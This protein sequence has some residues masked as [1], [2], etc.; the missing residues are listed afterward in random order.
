MRKPLSASDALRQVS[1]RKLLGN[2]LNNNRFNFLREPS[3]APSSPGKFRDRSVSV[4]RKSNEGNSYA[5]VAAAGT[6]SSSQ[7]AFYEDISETIAKV[8]SLCE[9]TETALRSLGAEPEII[10]VLQDLS[11]AV[12]FT[13]QIQRDMLIAKVSLAPPKTAKYVSLGSIPKKARTI[14]VSSQ[15]PAAEVSSDPPEV[16]KFKEAIKEAERSTLVFNLDMGSVPILNMDTVSKKATL[17]LTSMAAK[18]EGKNDSLPSMDAVAAIDDVL[19]VTKGMHFFGKA[20]K[21]YKNAKDPNSGK[22]Y[23]I[24]VKYNFKDKDTRI[25]AEITL[26]DRCKVNCSTPYPTILRECI[27]QSV[28][29]FKAKYPG[30][31]VRV[32]VDSANI[33]LKVFRRP[34]KGNQWVQLN[35]SIPLPNDVYNIGARSVPLGFKMPIE[36]GTPPAQSSVPESMD[37]EITASNRP[38]R[39]DS[40]IGSPAKQKK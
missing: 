25:R 29:H 22:Y 39:L 36:P 6:S 30:D 24:P 37:L 9:K 20:T 7:T 18:A 16:R 1:P 32:Q 31:L 17:A 23:T 34:E 26:R 33:A 11:D 12:R 4:K 5:D 27:R 35:K 13:N 8:S 2:S 15:K 3:P 10:Q 19:S 38:S 14:V 21:P 28:D 40:R